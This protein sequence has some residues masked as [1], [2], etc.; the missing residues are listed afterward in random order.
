LS[1]SYIRNLSIYAAIPSKFA[2]FPQS[3]VKATIFLEQLSAEV[4]T[5]AIFKGQVI[6]TSAC[7]LT[8]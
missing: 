4:Q 7:R 6:H 5:L 8:F 3:T 2:P 1:E